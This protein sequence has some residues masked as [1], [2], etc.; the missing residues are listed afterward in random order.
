[1]QRRL[2]TKFTTLLLG[3]QKMYRESTDQE[4]HRRVD[5]VYLQVPYIRLLAIPAVSGASPDECSERV[6]TLESI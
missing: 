1:M 5:V 4:L 3:S 6:M 2:P